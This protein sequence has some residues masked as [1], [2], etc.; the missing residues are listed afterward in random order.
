MTPQ[1]PRD[2]NYILEYQLNNIAISLGQTFSAIQKVEIIL[3]LFAE[4]SSKIR[5]RLKEI[6]TSKKKDSYLNCSFKTIFEAVFDVFD[7]LI[8]EDEK[9]RILNIITIRNKLAHGSFS[10]LISKI[11]EIY[12]ENIDNNSR[13]HNQNL[14]KYDISGGIMLLSS[15]KFIDK[16]RA[17][18]E[19]I[20]TILVKKFKENRSLFDN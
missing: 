4:N 13:Y 16:P 9:K 8:N 10:E 2:L 15:G 19:E 20:C 3:R 12:P 5:E 6:Q 1:I 18:A 14:D 11:K 7:S 17:D